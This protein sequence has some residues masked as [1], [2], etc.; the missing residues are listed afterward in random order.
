MFGL[1]NAVTVV[2]D[3]QKRLVIEGEYPKAKDTAK[4]HTHQSQ[5]KAVPDCQ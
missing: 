3:R 2:L 1:D 4:Y 5:K